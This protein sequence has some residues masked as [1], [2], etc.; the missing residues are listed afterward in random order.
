MDDAQAANVLMEI[1]LIG[2]APKTYEVSLTAAHGFSEQSN[3]WNLHLEMEKDTPRMVC[4]AGVMERNVQG[5]VMYNN[6]LGFGSSCDE[7]FVMVE[8]MVAS[9][10][11]QRELS[12]N[13]EEARRC[14]RLSRKVCTVYYS[15][16]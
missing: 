16:L 8:G 15:T 7:H 3:K 11:R 6:R 1:A 4:M 12:R 14:D 9:T 10:E 5:K 13:T 2:G